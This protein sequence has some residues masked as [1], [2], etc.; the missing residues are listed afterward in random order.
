MKYL[1]LLLVPIIIPFSPFILMISSLQLAQE[2]N[3]IKTA[4]VLDIS[5]VDMFTCEA[6]IYIPDYD[7]NAT[8]NI[9]CSEIIQRNLSDIL[10]A[11]NKTYKEKS[12]LRIIKSNEDVFVDDYDTTVTMF[13]ISL[14]IV[15][16]IIIVIIFTSIVEN[17]MNLNRQVNAI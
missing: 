8:L 17:C 6:Q 14:V 11:I 15:M 9:Q 4:K 12:C 7:Y 16:C 2:C 13:Y 3:Q 10:V 5:E 1:I